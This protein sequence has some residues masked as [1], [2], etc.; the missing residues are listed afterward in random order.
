MALL[1][2]AGILARSLAGAL[3]ALRGEQSDQEDGAHA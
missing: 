1:E 2:E 3:K